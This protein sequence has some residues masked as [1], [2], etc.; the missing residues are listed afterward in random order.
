VCY[1]GDVGYFNWELGVGLDEEEEEDKDDDTDD[2]DTLFDNGGAPPLP[3]VDSEIQPTDLGEEEALELE[4]AKS[5]L[6]ELGR[7][8][9]LAIK[10][11]ESALAQERPVMPPVTPT[12]ATLPAPPA[13]ST[14]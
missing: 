3:A 12:C 4:I 6:E 9:G 1:L 10:L 5:E 2:E 8:N 11:R 13:S 14:P 7:W